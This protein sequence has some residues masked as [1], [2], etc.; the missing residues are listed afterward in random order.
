MDG[1]DQRNS[2]IAAIHEVKMLYRI[3]MVGCLGY[4]SAIKINKSVREKREGQKGEKSSTYKYFASCCQCRC[5]SHRQ[6]CSNNVNTNISNR[7]NIE[8]HS[9]GHFDSVI[10][11]SVP[12]FLRQVLMKTKFFFACH[13]KE[14][15]SISVVRIVRYMFHSNETISK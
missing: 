11:A 4:P 9:I 8:V 2:K 7:M 3:L 5:R 13:S 10:F 1:K 15:S 14:D 12:F 6:E